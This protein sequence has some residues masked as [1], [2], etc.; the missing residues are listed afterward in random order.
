VFTL[1]RCAFHSGLK[2][3]YTSR[4]PINRFY[5][6]VSFI[7][8]RKERN[9]KRTVV[10][11]VHD[12]GMSFVSEWKSWSCKATGVNWGRYDLPGYE[13]LNGC[14]LSGGHYFGGPVTFG[15]MLYFVLSIALLVVQEVIVY[16]IYQALSKGMRLIMSKWSLK[17]PSFS[18]HTDSKLCIRWLVL[19]SLHYGCGYFMGVLWTVRF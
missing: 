15:L 7:L 2:W 13:I 4:F 18:F 11:R 9:I 12:T 16:G 17:L 8:E 1:Y 14:L 3:D 19:G 5:R 6:S 10:L